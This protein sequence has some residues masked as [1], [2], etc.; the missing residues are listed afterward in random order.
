VYYAFEV[1]ARQDPVLSA[2]GRVYALLFP[3]VIAS[4]LP[5]AWLLWRYVE[6][7]GQRGLMSLLPS[8]RRA[9]APIPAPRVPE[10]TVGVVPEV[11]WSAA[12]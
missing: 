4:T 6:E 8:R 11:A 5:L 2:G 12:R 7:P 10:P 1:I 9:A 3:V